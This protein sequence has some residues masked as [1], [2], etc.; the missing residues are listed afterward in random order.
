MLSQRVVPLS[1]L[2]PMHPGN[3]HPVGFVEM[4]NGLGMLALPV[5]DDQTSIRVVSIDWQRGT[6]TGRAGV[7]AEPIKPLLSTPDFAE[8]L[9]AQVNDVGLVSILPR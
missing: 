3:S 2:T 1:L 9:I 5:F 6:G 7:A 4:S 8:N